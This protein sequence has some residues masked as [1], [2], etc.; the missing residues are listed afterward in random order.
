MAK[1]ALNVTARI[2]T[3]RMRTHITESL[4]FTRFVLFQW[5]VYNIN[6]SPEYVHTIDVFDDGCGGGDDVGGG[7]D[8]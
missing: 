1:L 6:Q 5:L 4:H 7:G 8:N 2:F 3:N